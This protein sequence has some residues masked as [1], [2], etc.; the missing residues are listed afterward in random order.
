[1]YFV[2]RLSKEPKDVG[3][4]TDS[5]VNIGTDHTSG[6]N[7]G[8]YAK[9]STEENEV[10]EMQVGLSYTSEEN[11]RNNLETESNDKDFDFVRAKARDE[12]RQMLGRIRVESENEVDKIKFYTGLYHALLGRGISDDINCAYP[13]RTG[14][15]GQLEM[16]E[17]GKPKF[18]H[19]NTDGFWGGFWKESTSAG[20]Q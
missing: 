16:S 12:W 7:N 13:T 9:F 18:H 15:I 17:K 14:E 2:A 4:F 6:I 8:I 19:F 3:T 10:I 11:A 1:M 20:G 5:T